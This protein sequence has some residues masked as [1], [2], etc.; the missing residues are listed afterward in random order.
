MLRDFLMENLQNF[1]AN[2]Q[3]EYHNMTIQGNGANVDGGG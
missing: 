1:Q 3:Q 2:V